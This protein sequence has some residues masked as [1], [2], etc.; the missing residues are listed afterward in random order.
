MCASYLDLAGSDQV[1][2][3][4]ESLL[5]GLAYGHQAVVPQNEHLGKRESAPSSVRRRRKQTFPSDSTFI[6]Y[7]MRI[8][9][10]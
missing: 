10:I 4:I 9:Q 3:V 2:K 7:E 6:S 1:V 5:H 8:E